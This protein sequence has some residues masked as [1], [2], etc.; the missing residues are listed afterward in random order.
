MCKVDAD[1][2]AH[3]RVIWNYHRLHQ[4]PQPADI[5]IALGTNDLRVAEFAADLYHQGFGRML[6][7]TGGVAHTGDML[8]TGWD[9]PEAEIYAAIAIHRGVPPDR[10]LREPR[11]TNT[12]E[13]L[14]FTRRLLAEQGI[15]PASIVIAVKPFMQRRVWA[16]RAV[17][18]PEIPAT[19][20]SP[21]MTLDEYFT[22]E[23]PPE[24]I[25]HIMMGDLQRI[26][27]YGAKG[28]SQPQVIPP[29]VRTA[30]R[31]L[32]ERGFTKHLLPDN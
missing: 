9:K 6:I 3:A 7:C 13:N 4:Q 18:W 8:A 2:L 19:L 23:L 14:R 21:Q 32:V 16:T 25:I 15:A 26:W 12:A 11:S 30:Y 28:W 1:A 5:I 20:A 22:P 17:E 31:A 10:I 24:K 27:I 29:E